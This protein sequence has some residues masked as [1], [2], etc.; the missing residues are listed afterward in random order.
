MPEEGLII[1]LSNYKSYCLNNARNYPK[2]DK[3]EMKATYGMI[4]DKFFLIFG[5]SQIRI[6]T[7]EKEKK[8]FSNFGIS[9]SYFNSKGD[10]V[11]ALFC[12]QQKTN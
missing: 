2:K 3:K 10:K 7:G 11:N 4:Y 5:N 8:L 6:K 12:E 1:S 9:A